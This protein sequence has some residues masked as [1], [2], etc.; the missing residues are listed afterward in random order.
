MVQVWEDTSLL[1]W[2]HNDF[3]L[4]CGDLGNDVTDEVRVSCILVFA[5]TQKLSWIFFRF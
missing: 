2:D 4:F 5:M 1:T 3:R